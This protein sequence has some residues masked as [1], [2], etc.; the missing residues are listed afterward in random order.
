MFQNAVVFNQPL[1][2]LVDTS[3]I[4]N[5]SFPSMFTGATIFNQNIGAWDVSNATSMSYM[6]YN[7]SGFNN[8]GSPNIASLR[9]PK[10]TDFSSMF[11]NAIAFNQPL[12]NLVDTTTLSSCSFASMFQGATLFNQNSQR[13]LNQSTLKQ[14]QKRSPTTT[15]T[16]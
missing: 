2:N 7:A 15:T 16:R 3:T 6:F 5:C 13:R 10:C 4:S 9:A 8:G 1:D 14:H 11:R 12:T